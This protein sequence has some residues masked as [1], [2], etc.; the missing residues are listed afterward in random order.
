MI[1]LDM[2]NCIGG[3]QITQQQVRKTKA[4]DIQI[5]SVSL[6]MRSNLLEG[7]KF[8]LASVVVPFNKV[9]VFFSCRKTLVADKS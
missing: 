5:R 8:L 6:L 2:R 9:E 7:F 4:I 3:V 1:E